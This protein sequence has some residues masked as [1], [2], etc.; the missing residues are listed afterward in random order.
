MGLNASRRKAN[1]IPM[2][3]VWLLLALIILGL[4]AF[5]VN[6]WI[7]N[8]DNNNENLTRCDTVAGY[9]CMDKSAAQSQGLLIV[10]ERG[11]PAGQICA[12]G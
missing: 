1:S 7:K 2:F 5:V 4:L 3:L 8:W 11:C 12:G 10:G 9:S 6:K